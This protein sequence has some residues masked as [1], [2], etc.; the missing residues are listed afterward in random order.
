MTEAEIAYQVSEYLN[1]VWSMQ[2]WWAS[3][4]IGVLVMAHLASA[5]LNLLLVCISLALY[6]S[7]TLYMQQMS[8]ENVETLFALL[9][10]LEVLVDS[11]KVSSNNA[12]EL[13]KILATS[14][15]LFYLTFGGTYL[16]VVSYVIYSYVK[17]RGYRNT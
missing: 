3:I 1:R 17:T 10:D 2:Q 16:C 12:E 6:T 9:R 5:K 15:V 8:L 14:P 4:S 11:G 13:L 7:Y